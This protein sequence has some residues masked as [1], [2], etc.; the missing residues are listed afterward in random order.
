MK[1][2]F[3]TLPNSLFNLQTHYPLL[4]SHLILYSLS[5]WQW[6]SVNYK[7]INYMILINCCSM[8]WSNPTVLPLPLESLVRVRPRFFRF[9]NVKNHGGAEVSSRLCTLVNGLSLCISEIRI[10]CV[11]TFLYLMSSPG[12]L[13]V[14]QCLLH[15]KKNE[16][17]SWLVHPVALYRKK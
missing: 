8:K 12:C 7:Q 4:S 13:Y 9:Y 3:H 11:W 5:Y 10:A 16:L 15:N 17:N 6:H 14:Q 1:L 2:S